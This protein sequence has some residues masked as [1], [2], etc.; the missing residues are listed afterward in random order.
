MSYSLSSGPRFTS[1]AEDSKPGSLVASY[2]LRNHPDL[3]RGVTCYL[4]QVTSYM[5]RNHPDLN[6]GVNCY[7]TQ[8]A[9]SMLRNHPDL[10]RG[11]TAT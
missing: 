9:G 5:L 1:L 7:L 11:S 3:Y 8:V 6:R 10:Y 4:T 2:T